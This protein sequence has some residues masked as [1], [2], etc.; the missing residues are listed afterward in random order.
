VARSSFSSSTLLTEIMQRPLDPGYTAAARRRAAEED[1]GPGD[2]GPGDRGPGDRGPGGAGDGV[3]PARPGAARRRARRAGHGRRGGA[4][5]GVTGFLVLAGVVLGLVA[6]AAV[7]QLRQGP[8]QAQ[9]RAVLESEIERRTA[10]ADDVAQ[11]N[12]VL[13]QDIETEQAAAIGE[14]AGG[15]LAA[16][17]LLAVVSG[18]V[19]VAG[20]GVVVV[21]D[22]APSDDGVGGQT[23]ISDDSR[24]RDVD[25]QTIVNG[26]WSAGAEAVAVNGQRLTS[27][28][29]IRHAGDAIVVDLRQLAR[30]YTISA[31]GDQ[32][33]LLAETRTGAA[34]QWSAFLRD[35]YGIEVSQEAAEDVDLPS[36]SRLTLR[37]A[38]GVPPPGAGPVPQQEGGST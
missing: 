24:V 1:H 11:S 16:T 26:L 3:V 38:V 34:G 12:A 23:A 22:D 13:R 8:L 15:L 35:N 5:R 14:G 29:T 30:P 32:E 7:A 6:G 10:L 25:V 21:L 28:S 19:P 20:D 36:A 18:A 33:R 2:R 31:I 4:G 37:H 27:L 9:D 17:E